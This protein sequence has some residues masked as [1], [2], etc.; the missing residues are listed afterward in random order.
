MRVVIADDHPLVRSGVKTVLLSRSSN[1]VVAA[2]AVDGNEAL[3][4]VLRHQPD[5]LILDVSMPGLPPDA[6]IARAR[7]ALPQLKVLILTA[8][9]EDALISELSQVGINGYMLK[10]EAP[11]S[12]A[13]AVQAIEHGA[14]WFSQTVASK[15]MSF[16]R[17]PL[18]DPMAQFNSREREVT[19]HLANGL[20]NKEISKEM[21][22]AHQTVRNHVR[23]IYQKMGVGKR[24]DAVIWAR[25]HGL[26]K[27]RA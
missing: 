24:V 18:C 27:P 17:C 5:L 9:D 8:H 2:E 19:Q 14:A 20:N 1:T 11:E 10:E 23:T 7:Q 4:A 21:N 25:E 6:V 15:M 22:L 12:L 13:E 3:S 16:A 26:F